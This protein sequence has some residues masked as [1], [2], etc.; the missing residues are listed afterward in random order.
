VPAAVKNFQPPAKNLDTSCEKKP[1]TL[2]EPFA[3]EPNFLPGYPFEA[4]ASDIFPPGGKDF[5][6]G[7]TGLLRRNNTNE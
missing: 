5:F 2:P 3:G 7:E 6:T 4:T 1:A